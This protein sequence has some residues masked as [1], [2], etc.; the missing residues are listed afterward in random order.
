MSTVCPKNSY[1]DS[2]VDRCAPCSDICFKAFIQDTVAECKRQCPDY[3]KSSSEG[4]HAAS[5][6]WYIIGG[7]LSV[8][9]CLGVLITVFIM[10]RR[11]RLL[12]YPIQETGDTPAQVTGDT[13]THETGDTPT[14][15]TEDTP[16]N[17]TVV[18]VELMEKKIEV[19]SE[20]H[21]PLLSSNDSLQLLK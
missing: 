18:D 2:A 21:I 19:F 14:N 16:T 4:S 9:L 3:G 1:F 6:D 11:Q 17:E 5:F 8:F 15:E 10:R 12:R 20:I 7:I 13:H